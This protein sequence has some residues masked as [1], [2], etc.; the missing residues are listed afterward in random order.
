MLKENQAVSVSHQWSDAAW[1]RSSSAVS[2][3]IDPTGSSLSFV[4]KRVYAIPGVSSAD[5]VGE[6]LEVAAHPHARALYVAIHHG[7]ADPL[8]HGGPLADLTRLERP[9]RLWALSTLGMEATPP[10]TDEP[11]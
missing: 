10:S 2:S 8:V 11:Q 1:K 3:G 4:T 9:E 6:R 7:L 5:E